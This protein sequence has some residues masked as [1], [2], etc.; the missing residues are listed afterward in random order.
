ME[1][2]NTVDLIKSTMSEYYNVDITGE[3]AIDII[4]TIQSKDL[5]EFILDAFDRGW[6]SLFNLGLDED[7]QII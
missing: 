6:I 2:I 4:S 3:N 5:A 1:D 7:G